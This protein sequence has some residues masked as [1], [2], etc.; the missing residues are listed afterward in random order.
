MPGSHIPIVD[1][2]II[3]KEKPDFIIILPW[4]LKIEIERELS[5][6]RDWNGK[7]VI[8]VPELKI[9]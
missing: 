4:N 2:S 5:Y 3:K 6:I 8:A 9:F 7:F 1:E